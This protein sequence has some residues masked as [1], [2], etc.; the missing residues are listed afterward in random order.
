[1]AT[2]NPARKKPGWPYEHPYGG[3]RQSA[4]Y[5]ALRGLIL[6]IQKGSGDPDLSNIRA[7]P[8]AEAGRLERGVRHR[9]SCLALGLAMKANQVDR[10]QDARK[11]EHRSEPDH[12]ERTL[13]MVKS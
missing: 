9:P 2:L 5:S 8:R 13:Q 10:Q 12:D 6:D 1:M 4:A 3:V 11:K 7:K